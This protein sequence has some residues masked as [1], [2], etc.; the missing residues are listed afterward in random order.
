MIAQPTQQMQFSFRHYSHVF[1]TLYPC[2]FQNL[3]TYPYHCHFV[4]SR[5]VALLLL[6]SLVKLLDLCKR[7]SQAALLLLSSLVKLLDL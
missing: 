1:V 5:E 7:S 4:E 3:S 2:R 6:S